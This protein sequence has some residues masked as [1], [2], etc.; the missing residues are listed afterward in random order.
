[1]DYERINTEPNRIQEHMDVND[2]DT[3]AKRFAIQ[4]KKQYNDTKHI[5]EDMQVWNNKK[6]MFKDNM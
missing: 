4:I 6:E 1:M 2:I 3:D 5:I